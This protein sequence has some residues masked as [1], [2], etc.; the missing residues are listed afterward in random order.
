MITDKQLTFS[1]AQ[2][3]TTS[4]ASTNVVDLGPLTHGNTVRDIGAGEPVYLVIQVGEDA[5]A[6]GSA[7]VNFALQTDTVENFASPTV[8]FDSGAIGKADLTAGARPVAIAVPR[9]V[10]RY[11]RVNYTVSTGPLTAGTFSAYLVKDV[12]DATLYSSGF[13]VGGA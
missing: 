10:E 9:G 1:E 8:L 12:G 5:T 3:V 6:S 7:T 4:A 11:L 13:A 2:A